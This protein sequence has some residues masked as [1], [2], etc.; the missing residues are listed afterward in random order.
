MVNPL[1]KKLKG[2][3]V[4][5]SVTGMHCPSCAMTIDGALEDTEGVIKSSTSY[6]KSTIDIEYDPAKITKDAIL[7]I[8]EREGYA[9]S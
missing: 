8:V 7:K 9:I 6:A 1:V 4:I 3:Q 2:Q 5:L